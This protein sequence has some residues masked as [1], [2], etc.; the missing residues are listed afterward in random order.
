MKYKDI[1]EEAG[2]YH[3]VLIQGKKMVVLSSDNNLSNSKEKAIKEI[4]E[5]NNE[6]E[7]LFVAKLS[8]KVISEK[9]IKLNEES[10]IKSIT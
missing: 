3:F 7:D 2:K 5:K 1:V 9:L 8:I 6:Y 4:E 10:K